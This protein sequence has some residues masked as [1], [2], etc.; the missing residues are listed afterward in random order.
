MRQCNFIWIDCEKYIS[1]IK[2]TNLINDNFNSS[3]R[4]G[5]KFVE[6]YK[7]EFIVNGTFRR[8][9]IKRNIVEPF[10]TLLFHYFGI[11]YLKKI[12]NFNLNYIII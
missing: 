10:E 8:N 2:V 12:D 9:K 4:S 3:I 11:I 1:R 6:K 5:N 7:L